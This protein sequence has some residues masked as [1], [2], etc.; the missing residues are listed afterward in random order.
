MPLTMQDLGVKLREYETLA[1]ITTD[2]GTMSV[3][4]YIPLEKKDIIEIFNIATAK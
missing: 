1:D 4:S 3:K 2:G